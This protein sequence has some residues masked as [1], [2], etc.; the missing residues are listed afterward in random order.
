MS[1][2][3]IPELARYSHLRGRRSSSSLAHC[4]GTRWIQT[5]GLEI[6]GV[7]I[8]CTKVFMGPVD[9]YGRTVPVLQFSPRLVGAQC[10]FKEEARNRYSEFAHSNGFTSA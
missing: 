1:S 8:V 4:H 10:Y 7:S 9:E 2:D 6:F 3:V 5:P